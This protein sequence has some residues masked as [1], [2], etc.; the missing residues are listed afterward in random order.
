MRRLALVLA[1][2]FGAVTLAGCGLCWKDPI[3]PNT[4]KR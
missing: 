3:H 4:S 2:V 1:V